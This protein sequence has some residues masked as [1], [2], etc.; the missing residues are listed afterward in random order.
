[1]ILPSFYVFSMKR[2]LFSLFIVFATITFANAQSY[3]VEK[4][5]GKCVLPGFVSVGGSDDEIFANIVLWALQNTETPGMESFSVLNYK[6]HHLELKTEQKI[7]NSSYLAILKVDVVEGRI[8]FRAENIVWQTILIMSPKQT[9]FEKL[10]PEKRPAHQATIA[11]FERMESEL[12]DNMIEFAKTNKLPKISH[13]QEIMK[14]N[15]VIGMTETE[16]LLSVGNPRL[17]LEGDTETQWQ[18]SSSMYIFFK[19]GLVSSVVK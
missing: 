16:C 11:E 8:M 15:V 19:K 13:W 12:I 1:M 7:N 18:I 5:D 9:P 4:V 14:N 17:K 2:I 10:Q 6:T 3:K